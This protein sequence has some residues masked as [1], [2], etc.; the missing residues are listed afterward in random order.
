[1][2]GIARNLFVF[3]L[4]Y[5]AERFIEL[6]GERFAS[7]A[8]TVRSAD[9]AE[10]LQQRGI[11][12]LPFSGALVDDVLQRADVILVSI[13]PHDDGDTALT[14]YGESILRAKRCSWIGYLSTTGVYGDQGGQPTDESTPVNPGTAQS[15]WRVQAE[16][17]WLAFGEKAGIPTHI[18]RLAGI[19]GPGR[20]AFVSL[21]NGTAQRIAKAGQ[22][23]N[24]IHVDDIAAVL[25][26]AMEKPKAGA[27]YNV[28]DDE[29]A[30]P[31]DVVQHAAHLMGIA[32][33]PIIAFEEA[34]LSSVARGFY[35]EN[36]SI[37]NDLLKNELGVCLRYPTY[38][39]GL[40]ALLPE[41]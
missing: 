11:N 30:P 22:I 36:K 1:M 31:Q 15:H 35:S 16:R 39:E 7:V 4:G 32:P 5:S 23:F 20:N 41:T 12:A 33:P 10:R 26:A 9:K 28:S 14:A 19:Y 25:M 18:L 40:A 34:E 27:I 13:P 24:R 29:P 8:G 6:Y 37:T 2:T 17:D 21:N 3:G 38:R